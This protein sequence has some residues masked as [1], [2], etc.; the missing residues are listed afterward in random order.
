MGSFL[1]A[2]F[3]KGIRKFFADTFAQIRE[4]NKKYAVPQIKTNAWTN[5]AL[6]MLRA[7][8]VVLILLLVYK[9]ITLLK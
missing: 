5:F 8:L 9:F 6:V 7:Y 1:Y 2:V 4:I 3:I